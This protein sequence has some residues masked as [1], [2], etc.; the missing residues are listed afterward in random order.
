LH[1]FPIRAGFA[2]W[3]AGINIHSE[4]QGRP[5]PEKP[6]TLAQVIN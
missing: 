1:Y 6:A 5:S 3:T 2:R 4:L